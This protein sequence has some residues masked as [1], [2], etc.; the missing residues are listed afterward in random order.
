LKSTRAKWIDDAL[1]KHGELLVLFDGKVQK[2]HIYPLAVTGIIIKKAPL[3]VRI[4][5]NSTDK[6]IIPQ[7]SYTPGPDM[8]A[9]ISG[10]LDQFNKQSISHLLWLDA[11]PV[12]RVQFAVGHGSDTIFLKYYVSEKY[13]S[14]VYCH[15]NEPVYKDTCVEFFISFEHDKHY[16]NLEFNCTGTVLGMYGPDKINRQFLDRQLLAAIGKEVSI[17][18]DQQTQLFEWELT[19]AIPATVFAFHY[20]KDLAGMACCLNFF[21]CG[22]DLPVPHYLAWN[23][24]CRPEPDFHRPEWFGKGL[25]G[26][27]E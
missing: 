8:L 5:M 23:E 7:I 4:R 16:Y 27:S 18:F 17:R 6:L 14:A 26:H 12:P 15:T 19:I 11:A 22:D 21:K 9:E 10:K 3:A 25:F 1:K 20:I 2:R 24:I 13:I